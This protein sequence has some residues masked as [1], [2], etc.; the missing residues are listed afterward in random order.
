MKK[1]LNKKTTLLS[2][3][4]IISLL[5]SISIN[6]KFGITTLFALLFMYVLMTNLYIIKIYKGSKAYKA[7]NYSK[8]LD[9]YRSA[10]I[11]PWCNANIIMDYLICE[12]KYGKA[13][14]ANE[15]IEEIFSKR[16]FKQNELLNL[17]IIEAI[18]LWRNNKKQNAITLL[19]QLL[20]KNKNT[21]LYETLTSILICNGN[22]YEAKTILSDALSFNKD[23]NI[24]KSNE[25]EINFKEGNYNKS[26]EIF[27]ALIK[28]D[29]KFVEPFYYLALIEMNNNNLNKSKA[30]LETAQNLN[31]SLITLV[32]LEDIE[33]AYNKVIFKSLNV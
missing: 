14:I 33:Q 24:L 27:S 17:K 13:S 22:I 20:K 15:Y 23:S 12:L 26:Y 29:I 25:G 2:A 32:K 1:N 6:I 4:V 11:S 7:E 21:F 9:Y 16:T 3:I 5:F 28:E 30:L 8:T 10:I 18:V 31:E 19:K